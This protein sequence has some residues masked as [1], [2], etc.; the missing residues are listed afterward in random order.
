MGVNRIQATEAVVT[1]ATALAAAKAADAAKFAMELGK[2]PPGHTNV[3]AP[4][5]AVD[6][7]HAKEV[8]ETAKKVE[9][10]AAKDDTGSD[11]N[12]VAM[13]ERERMPERVQ[14]ARE[15]A[16]ASDEASVQHIDK[17]DQFPAEA[18]KTDGVDAADSAEE[19]AVEETNAAMQ[20]NDLKIPVLEAMDNDV[21]SDE[22]L[23]KRIDTAATDTAEAKESDV[24]DQKSVSSK[25]DPGE[26]F[27]HEGE[28]HNSEHESDNSPVHFAKGAPSLPGL[29]EDFKK[30]PSNQVHLS[31]ADENTP[32]H[33]EALMDPFTKREDTHNKAAD[34]DKHEQRVGEEM[35]KAHTQHAIQAN[36]VK[37]DAELMKSDTFDENDSKH[38]SAL[39]DEERH[40]QQTKSVVD[41]ASISMND[42]RQK[43]KTKD[44]KTIVPENLKKVKQQTGAA[45][46]TPKSRRHSKRHV[47]RRHR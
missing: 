21:T 33:V 24:A 12:A 28:A 23:V 8:A 47:H 35:M 11:L 45:R 25:A 17:V 38:V 44:T 30:D 34:D 3:E 10:A 43:Q 42:N 20:L 13:R 15:T 2:P 1:S 5:P 31:Q 32:Q 36:V 46:L 18:E 22:G 19:E 39:S 40:Q 14:Q 4:I 7:A 27:V 16:L 26:A 6:Q 41:E 37:E 9:D 29:F